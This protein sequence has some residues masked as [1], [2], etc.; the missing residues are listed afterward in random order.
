[1][2]SINRRNFVKT[3]GLAAGA[4]VGPFIKTATG[5][6]NDTI[7]V[8]VAGIRGRG[9]SHYEAFSKI[10][11]VRVAY[12]VD[13]DERE[14]PKA[15]KN[16]SAY[17]PQAPKTEVDLRR[18]LDDKEVDVIAIATP[19]HWHALQTI[20]AC[21]AG[22]D[23][24]VEKPASHN[25]FEGRKMVEAS[26]KYNRIVQVGFQNR[27]IQNVRKAMEFLHN[28]GIGKVYMAKGLCF[29]PRESIGR[30]PDGPIPQGVHYD[31]W[32][33]PAPY[34]PFNPVRFH[35][36]WHWFWDTGSGD[37]GNQ[38][39]HQFD[40]ARWGLNKQEHPV[41][42]S[43]I[44]GYYAFDSM[45]E[46]PNTQTS[47]FE[48]ADG[49]VLEF[50][51]RGLYTNAE[52]DIRIGNLFYGTDGWMHLDGGNWKTYM[53]RK[54]EPGTSATSR[55]QAD[56]SNLRGTGHG[57]H[58]ENFINAVRSRNFL[59]LNCDVEEGHRSTALP[60]LANISYRL[61]REV[62]FDSHSERFVDDEQANGYLSRKYRHPYVV[63]KEV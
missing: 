5:S 25:I 7:N 11:N 20:W 52:D 47:V 40:V 8:A 38:G 62:E 23:V 12:L 33:G 50:E 57:P 9:E 56:P 60:H 36:N 63:P 49:T 46:T 61:G 15:L 4:A 26:R 34:K 39:P 19:N 32:L 58:F 30:G 28:G 45:Q 1:M 54:N 29:K 31:L 53:G 59:E 2:S 21:Q 43:S 13:I 44:G 18:V 42:I 24:Y 22:K 51:T 3:A 37:T 27:S 6:P 48:Y 55:D 10:P 17:A 14:F 16:M 35:Y 41:R